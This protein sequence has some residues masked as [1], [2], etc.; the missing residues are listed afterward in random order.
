ML[1]H[2]VTAVALLFMVG[3][4]ADTPACVVSFW[5][6]GLEAETGDVW[7]AHLKAAGEGREGGK[8]TS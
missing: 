3:A 4:M 6:K 8:G 2:L 5:W 7:R 1:I